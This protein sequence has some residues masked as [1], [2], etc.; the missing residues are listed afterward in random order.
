MSVIDAL[1]SLQFPI[2]AN[3]IDLIAEVAY[4]ILYGTVPLTKEETAFFK[5]HKPS[6]RVLI[7]KYSLKRKLNVL[8]EDLVKKLVTAAIR[9][10][11]G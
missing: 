6:L 11:D 4:N 10:L 7:S 5:T 8:T 3:E 2:K 9:H 1:R